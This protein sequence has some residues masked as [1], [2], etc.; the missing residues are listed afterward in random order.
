MTP[1]HPPRLLEPGSR[2][3]S[4]PATPTG[5]TPTGQIPAGQSPVDPVPVLESPGPGVIPERVVPS[6]AAPRPPTE[7]PMHLVLTAAE[8]ARCHRAMHLALLMAGARLIDPT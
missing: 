2:P 1:H 6:A 8:L 3:C 5:P 7:T 4:R